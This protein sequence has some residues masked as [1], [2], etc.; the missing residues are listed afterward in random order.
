MVKLHKILGKPIPEVDIKAAKGGAAAGGTTTASGAV[1]T[2]PKI[3][4]VQSGNLG[5]VGNKQAESKEDAKDE[6]ADVEMT[7]E[8]EVTPVGQEYIEE[9]RS[10]DG[11]Y[12]IFQIL[13]EFHLPCMST[14]AFDTIF[15][16][17][18]QL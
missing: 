13:K 4:F 15:R 16:W 17:L 11:E 9:M 10:E 18:V 6:S 8:N 12:R 7:P 2:P 1:T 3:N 5:T 14:C